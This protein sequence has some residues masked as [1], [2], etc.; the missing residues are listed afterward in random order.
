[1]NRVSAQGNTPLAS[2]FLVYY[3]IAYVVLIGAMG[4]F[5]LLSAESSF[6]TTLVDRLQTDV[7]LARAGMPEDTTEFQ[8]WVD[9]MS[10][11][12]GYR[13][14]VID[15]EGVVRGGLTSGSGGD[16]EPLRPA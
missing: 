12:S 10:E 14:T 8:A 9:Q 15:P 7:F 4:W 3:A 5:I 6:T 1:M 11:L 2:R 16:G 13:F